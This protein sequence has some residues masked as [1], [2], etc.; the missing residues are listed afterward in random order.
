MDAM[1]AQCMPRIMQD[2]RHYM[3]ATSTHEFVVFLSPMVETR[4]RSLGGGAGGRVAFHSE[5]HT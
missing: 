5:F 2:P 4:L 3:V 1:G